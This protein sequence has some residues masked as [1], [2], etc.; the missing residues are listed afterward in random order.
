MFLRAIKSS[1]SLPTYIAVIY[2]MYTLVHQFLHISITIILSQLIYSFVFFLLLLF[3]FRY[4]ASHHIDITRAVSLMSQ[5]ATLQF[6][7]GSCTENSK[8]AGSTPCSTPVLAAIKPLTLTS[9]SRSIS[10]GVAVKREWNES[11]W[12]VSRLDQVPLNFP[13]ERTRREI[14]NVPVADIASRISNSLRLLSIEAEYDGEKGKVKCR[15]SD[16]VS[17]RIRLFA[18]NES[19]QEPVIVEIQRRSGSPSCFMRVCKNILD[20]AEGI[21]VQAETVP[22]RKKIPPWMTK[23]PVSSMKCLVDVQKRDPHKEANLGIS[24]SLDLLRSKDKDV[25]VLGLENLCYLTDTLKT[26][27]DMAMISCKAI[28]VG[29][30]ST[31]IR[32]EIGI[33]LQKDTFL[34]EEFEVNAIKDLFD[35]CRHLA[36][37][38]LT[39]VLALTSQD[40]SLADAVQNQKWFAEFL[41]PSLLDEVKSFKTSS[42]NAHEAACGLTYL[43][44][45]SDIAR[46]VMEENAAVEDLQSANQFAVCNHELLA[47]ETKRSL[48]ALGYPI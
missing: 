15:T 46:R 6:S 14:Q 47:S 28:I 27:P 16:M 11:N 43:A 19:T 1:F 25:N 31:E 39:N 42:N 45:C 32:D 21:E 36:I 20:G 34:P 44:T 4:Y 41:I 8:S 18:G 10:E 38:L 33:L 30:H 40:G 37:V 3:L 29:E 23:T 2:K 24:K 48:K 17:F 12:K 26:R 13:L 22:A 35:K 7:L 9:K 5:P